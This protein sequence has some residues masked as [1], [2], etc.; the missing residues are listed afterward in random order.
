MDD[1][2]GQLIFYL[3]VIAIVIAVVVAII[4]TILSIGIFIL[5]GIAVVG[6]IGGL[7][8]GTMNFFEVLEEAHA[9]LP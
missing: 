8:K 6:M 7:I 1:A 2:L 5:A 4:G 3:V 9:K